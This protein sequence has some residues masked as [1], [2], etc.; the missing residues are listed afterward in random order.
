MGDDNDSTSNSRWSSARLNLIRKKYKITQRELADVLGVHQGNVSRWQRALYIPLEYWDRLD[1]LE[2]KL[3]SRP[4][5]TCAVGI[6]SIAVGTDTYECPFCAEVIKKKAIL[7][8]HC[9]SK[10]EHNI[11]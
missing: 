11:K 10:I 9:H 3:S 4:G 7:C 1:E 6:P 5:D 8:K 2:A